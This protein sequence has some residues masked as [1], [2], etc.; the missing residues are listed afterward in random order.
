MIC[1][2]HF[3]EIDYIV[4]NGRYK[5]N[6]NAVPLIYASESQEKTQTVQVHTEISMPMTLTEH[7]RETMRQCEENIQTT[8]DSKVYDQPF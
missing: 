6:K 8:Q 1:I 2:K 7:R 4:K 5:L 3:R